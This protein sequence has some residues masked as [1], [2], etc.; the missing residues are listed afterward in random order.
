MAMLLSYTP[1]RPGQAAADAA[2]REAAAH[3]TSLVVL[4]V[5]RG[6][7]LVENNTA[8]EAELDGIVER[9]REAGVSATIER[10]ENSDIVEAV[11]DAAAGHNADAIVIGL[12]RRTPVGKL[13]LG[14]SAQRILLEAPCP[15]I[16]VKPDH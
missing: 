11:L 9:A 2:I 14:S 13:F 6:G 10:P 3:E 15:V 5:R 4:N 7:A 12:R 1:T 8:S 16:A